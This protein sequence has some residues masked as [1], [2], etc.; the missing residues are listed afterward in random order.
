[1]TAIAC[2]CGSVRLEAQGAPMLSAVC[3]CT[4]CRTAG[5]ALDAAS[6]Q[7]P[8]VDASG[9][10]ACVLWRKD[11]LRC[12]AGGA[13]LEPHR[14]MPDSPTRR[15]V[16]S[17]CMTPVLL[18]FTRG[19]W[20]SAY[21]DRVADA[22]P[23][24][25]RLMTGDAPGDVTLPDDGLPRLRGFSGRFMVKLL[26]TWAMMGFRTPGIAGLGDR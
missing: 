8:I 11:R 14:L 25:M 2:A 23:P 26:A 3:H 13:L 24:T 19:F 1:M 4:S 20:A 18:D 10:T 5:Q 22:P 7:D 6:G 12:I 9:G 15:L 21:R 17:C 16:A